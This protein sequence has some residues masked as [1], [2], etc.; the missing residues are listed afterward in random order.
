ILP[1]GQLLDLLPDRRAALL[2]ISEDVVLLQRGKISL[3]LGNNHRPGTELPVPPA[4]AAS[5]EGSHLQGDHLPAVEGN[6]PAQRPGIA[7]IVV[8]PAHV[9]REAQVGNDLFQEGLEQSRGLL[10]PYFFSYI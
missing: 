7:Q 4:D 6:D 2:S 3:G 5:L 8:A 10:T 9:F 1:T